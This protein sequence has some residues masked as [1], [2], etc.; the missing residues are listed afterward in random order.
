MHTCPHYV[1]RKKKKKN[2]IEKRIPLILD[3]FLKI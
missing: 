1:E 3:M 2:Y